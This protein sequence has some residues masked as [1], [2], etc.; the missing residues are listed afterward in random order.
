M[1]SINAFSVKFSSMRSSA[2][3]FSFVKIQNLNSKP[4][5]D[6]VQTRNPG[7]EKDVRVL[8][9]Y[10]LPVHLEK[11]FWGCDIVDSVTIELITD[12]YGK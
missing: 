7:L 8:N 2:S 6:L 5:F 12:L 9:P 11:G 3:P 4:G 1:P 10:F